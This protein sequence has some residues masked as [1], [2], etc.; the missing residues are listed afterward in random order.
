[1]KALRILPLPI[2]FSSEV[3]GFFSL[4]ELHGSRKKLKKLFKIGSTS[5][6]DK[7]ALT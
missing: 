5:A 4:S 7:S 3:I 2:K 1:V 6:Q